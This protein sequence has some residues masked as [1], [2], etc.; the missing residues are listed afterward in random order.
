V[1]RRVVWQRRALDDLAEI[2]RRDRRAAQRI[3]RSVDRWAET[4]RGDV[5]KL[6]ASQGLYRL[7]VG[8]F[9]VIF[10]FESDGIAIL[11]LRARN[12]REAYRD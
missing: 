3:S 12:R 6:E 8:D 11:V 2:T 9:R 4:G 10:R 5:R 1:T 7:R